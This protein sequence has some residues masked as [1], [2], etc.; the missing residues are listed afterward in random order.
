MNV[1]SGKQ[2]KTEKPASSMK[3]VTWSWRG[4]RRIQ[5]VMIN[6]WWFYDYKR[7]LRKAVALPWGNHIHVIVLGVDI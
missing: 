7:G 2:E 4:K 3:S 1:N 6:C 5:I